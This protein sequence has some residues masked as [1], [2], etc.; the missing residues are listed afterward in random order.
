MKIKSFLTVLMAII[1]VVTLFSSCSK[2]NSSEQSL[3]H[4]SPVMCKYMLDG[5]TPEEF[6]ESNGKNTFLENRY[7]QSEVDE[8]GCLILTLKNEVV[9]EWKNTFRDLQILQC[10]FGDTRDIGI[11]VDY[12]KDFMNYMKNAHTCGYEISED[13]TQIIESPEDNSWYFPFVNAACATMQVFE[14]KTCSEIKVE[15]IEI[16][17]NGEI[18]E[19]VVFPGDIEE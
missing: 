15:H 16:D 3:L 10:V 18:I 4:M 5:V 19:K 2:E 12:S 6:Y 14:G 7:L 11:T 17:E 9:S 13:F 8:D 1:F